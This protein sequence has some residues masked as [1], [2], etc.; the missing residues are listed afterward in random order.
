MKDNYILPNQNKI[1]INVIKYKIYILK[2]L[3]DCY[4][5]EWVQ[6]EHTS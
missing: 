3:F 6:Q 4:L 1:L 2:L 5:Q